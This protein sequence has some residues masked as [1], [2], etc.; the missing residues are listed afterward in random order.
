MAHGRS[1]FKALSVNQY[2]ERFSLMVM[3]C[4]FYQQYEDKLLELLSNNFSLHEISIRFERHFANILTH[5]KAK[6]AVEKATKIQIGET[7]QPSRLTCNSFNK[8]MPLT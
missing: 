4:P 1:S 2:L 5:H 3:F 7:S 6:Q 8:K